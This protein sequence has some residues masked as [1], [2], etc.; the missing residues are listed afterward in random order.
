MT[1]ELAGAIA[2]GALGWESSERDDARDLLAE[3]PV[4]FGEVLGFAAVGLMIETV[5]GAGGD[6]EVDERRRCGRRGRGRIDGAAKGSASPRGAA[7]GMALTAAGAAR[8]AGPKCGGKCRE[9]GR[10]DDGDDEAG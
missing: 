8:E 1:F 9:N 2:S 6:V 7:Y 5:A 4:A 10:H 3:A